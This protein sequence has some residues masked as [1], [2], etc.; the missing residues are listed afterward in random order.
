[1]DTECAV[2]SV[3]QSRAP[4]IQPLKIINKCPPSA[5]PQVG[6]TNKGPSWSFRAF[7]VPRVQLY[8]TPLPSDTPEVPRLGLYGV[9]A[10]LPPPTTPTGAARLKQL[11]LS[12]GSF[13]HLHFIFQNFFKLSCVLLSPFPFSSSM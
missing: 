13:A 11:N 7:S 8:P 3:P 1:M 9:N 5:R 2:L 4:L 10:P 6:R 12:Q